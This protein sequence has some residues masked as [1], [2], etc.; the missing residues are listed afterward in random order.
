MGTLDGAPA[1]QVVPRARSAAADAV[2]VALR[3]ARPLLQVRADRL[4]RRQGVDRPCFVLT[5]DCDTDDDIAVVPEVHERLRRSGITPAYAVPGEQLAAGADVYRAVAASGAELL[6]H[7]QARHC[8]FDPVARTYDSSFFYDRLPW[9]D[10]ER[11]IR[12]GH[13]THLDVVG[14][15]PVGFRVPHFGTFQ[16]RDRLRRLHDLLAAMGYRYSSSTMPLR[17][18]LG[19]PVQ[20]TSQGVVELPVTGRPTAPNRVLD[21]WSFRFAP[22]RRVDE[23]D[24]ERELAMLVDDLLAGRRRVVNVYAD[25]SQVHDWPGFFHAVARAAPVALPSLAAL[26]E[27][28]A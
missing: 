2:A 17:G 1:R 3:A 18:L 14:R 19:G 6:N 16:R 25:P 15:A 9:G 4:A 23:R 27:L 22:G 5:F 21:S 10:V 8:T 13:D 7:G 12:G 20:R 24:Y 28:A 11:D 26:V